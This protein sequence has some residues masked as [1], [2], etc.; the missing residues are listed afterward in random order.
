[1]PRLNDILKTIRFVQNRDG[2]GGVLLMTTQ[3]FFEFHKQA[4][5]LR[6]SLDDTIPT[7]VPRLDVVIRP[8][9]AADLPLFAGIAPSLRLKR[10]AKKL[11]A[12][13]ACIVGIYDNRVIS[14]TWIGFAET[15]TLVETPLKLTAKEA[16]L[17]GGYMDPQYRS[18]G[19]NTAMVYYTMHW[20]RDQ[21]YEAVF[22]YT[23]RYNKPVLR[24]C[25]KLGFD[26]VSRLTS[27]RL[28]KWQ[29]SWYT[30]VTPAIPQL[31]KI[32]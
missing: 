31:E 14:T 9:A 18:K 6:R 27:V 11:E 5:V 30:A 4:F 16:Y 23:E 10:F 19:V 3:P 26:V 2:W 29:K 1:M 22:M 7:A 15:P 20:L 21:G 28:L 8:A 17:W 13:E 24:L 32:N 25:E 12:G